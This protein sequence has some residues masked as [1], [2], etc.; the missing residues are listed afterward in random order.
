MKISI[1][2]KPNSR[3]NTV[4]QIDAANFLVRVRAKP[5]DGKANE[6][7]IRAL[8]EYLRIPPSL[9]T[10]TKGAKGREKLI[11]INE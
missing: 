10:I 8:A 11:T 1:K 9:I 3:N 4:E 2:V 6:A 5:Q 7:V